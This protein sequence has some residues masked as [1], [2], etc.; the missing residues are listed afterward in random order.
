MAGPNTIAIR[1][2]GFF[3]NAIKD[4]VKAMPD[5]KYEPIGKEWLLRKDLMNK[6]FEDISDLCIDL[7]VKIVPIPDFVA[8]LARPSVPFSEK[9]KT[10]NK[11][12]KAAVS[13]GR[14]FNYVAETGKYSLD[15]LPAKMQE[16]LYAF[17]RKG[18]EFGLIRCGR[19]LLGDEMG[20]GKTLQAL[21]I[22]YIYKIDWP[23]LIVTP[24]SLRHT[25]KDEIAKWIP[26]LQPDKDIQL[27][28]KGKDPWNVDACVFIFS[29]DLATKRASEIEAKGFKACIADEAHYLKSRDSKRAQLLVPIMM[30]AKRSIL[31]SGT[32]M[33]SRPVEIYNLMKILRPD[34]V[35]SF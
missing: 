19:L 10:S 23:L 14:E 4:K 33:L 34:L 12:V 26:T 32:P 20:V 2:E 30:R 27:F 13:F 25:W 3:E 29:Y 8:D 6:L 11:D 7:G 5:S 1:F 18:I 24:S 17:Q 9:A 35:T 28:R 15:S 31:I 22:A 16:N 21:A